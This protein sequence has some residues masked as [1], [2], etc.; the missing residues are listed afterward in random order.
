M[1]SLQ[2]LANDV[3][4]QT[5]TMCGIS[6]TWADISPPQPPFCHVRVYR[7]K[8]CP[9]CHGSLPSDFFALATRVGEDRNN[10]R[11]ACLIQ[12]LHLSSFLQS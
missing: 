6:F 12:Y 10:I 3:F 2:L 4:S 7:G 9:S 11:L 5:L 1:G 8:G